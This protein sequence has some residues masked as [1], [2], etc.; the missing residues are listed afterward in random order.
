ML[1]HCRWQTVQ[2]HALSNVSPLIPSLNL[3]P[4]RFRLALQSTIPGVQYFNCS[5]V[6]P[7]EVVF[8]QSD[9]R[10]I[11]L[12][13]GLWRVSQPRA[14]WYYPGA[15]YR[16]L[17]RS[18]SRNATKPLHTT[19]VVPI[20]T[21]LSHKAGVTDVC[22]VIIVLLQTLFKV[23]PASVLHFSI[24]A[25]ANFWGSGLFGHSK[26]HHCRLHFE[27]VPLGSASTHRRGVTFGRWCCQLSATA[28]FGCS[29]LLEVYVRYSQGAKDGNC[30]FDRFWQWWVMT[31][32]WCFLLLKK[33]EIVIGFRFQH[34]EPDTSFWRL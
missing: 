29:F 3:L 11:D 27:P 12:I 25:M 24:Q 15:D 1:G 19:S 8:E 23:S 10:L 28:R 7:Q 4:R 22:F 31:D 16:R 13:S 20:Q 9:I 32:L 14:G 17:G 21:W 26:Y 34:L 18:L 30:W 2:C 6:T 5:T 33:H